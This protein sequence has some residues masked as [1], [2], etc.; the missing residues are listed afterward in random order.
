MALA[1]P[2]A[3]ACG[4]IGGGICRKLAIMAQE[5]ATGKK[6]SETEIG[7]MCTAKGFCEDAAKEQA[8][9]SKFIKD[10]KGYCKSCTRFVA[11]GT[12]KCK[13]ECQ[14]VCETKRKLV[15]IKWLGDF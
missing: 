6:P 3:I 2:V 1:P 10:P 5:T 9:I 8:I 4:I 15:E 12:E 14:E 7:N 11:L 13:W